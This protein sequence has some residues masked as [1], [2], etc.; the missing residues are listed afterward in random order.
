MAQ[1]VKIAKEVAKKKAWKDLQKNA[2]VK[3]IQR[4]AKSLGVRLTKAKLAQIIPYTGAIVGGGFNAYYTDKVCD[5]SYYLY[6]ERF[7]AAK[8]GEDVIEETVKPAENFFPNY[9]DHIDI[10]ENVDLEFNNNDDEE[11]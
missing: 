11:D 4:I 8:Y 9:D 1:L 7:L 2:F 6:R 5:A 10:G 3:I